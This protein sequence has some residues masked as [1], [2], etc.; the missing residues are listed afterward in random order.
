VLLPL[1][2][3]VM[4]S[5]GR[6]SVGFVSSVASV[7]LS[8]TPL[9]ETFAQSVR[10]Y[11]YSRAGSGISLLRAGSVTSLDE[12]ALDRLRDGGF[13]INVVTVD[14]D[15]PFGDGTREVR[16]DG[17]PREDNSAGDP[18]EVV[19]GDLR[20]IPL[21]PRSFDIVHCS[22]L[23]DRIGHVPLV[24]DRLCAAL[25][26]GGI[27]LIRIRERDCA[28]GFLDRVLPGWVRRALWTRLYPGQP[29]PFRPVYEPTASVRGIEAYILMRGLVIAQRKTA[30]TLPTEPARLSRFVSLLRA[31]V[32][33]AS[34]G[35]LTDAYDEALFVIRK[36]Q[37]RFAR[38]VLARVKQHRAPTGVT[39]PEHLGRGARP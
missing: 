5:G 24:L 18:L 13:E 26:P 27:L 33:A 11:A 2:S 12:L 34:R 22:L 16:G 35:R 29:G 30:R 15:H 25:R 31:T 17:S 3:D 8:E 23:L 4:N 6:G 10:D 28:A 7:A 37:D 9:A 1:L 36:P 39:Y 21:P 38:V 19:A 14:Q 20:T 32:A